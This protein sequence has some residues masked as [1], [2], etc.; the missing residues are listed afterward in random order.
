[1]VACLPGSSTVITRSQLRWSRWQLAGLENGR[2][3]A[4]IETLKLTKLMQRRCRSRWK[5]TS[6]STVAMALTLDSSARSPG[7]QGSEFGLGLGGEDFANTGDAERFDRPP[8]FW[9]LPGGIA[10]ELGID[11]GPIGFTELGLIPEDG[12]HHGRLELRHGGDPGGFSPVARQGPSG[13]HPAQG[14]SRNLRGGDGQVLAATARYSDSLRFSRA[15][16]RGSKAARRQRP[17]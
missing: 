10:G 7:D 11:R 3:A 13:G 6:L 8:P 1:M 16:A 17:K 4:I 2:F 5:R 9:P 12:L 15:A 14:E